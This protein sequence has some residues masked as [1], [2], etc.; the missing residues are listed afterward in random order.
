MALRRASARVVQR[1]LP[2]ATLETRVGARLDERLHAGRVVIRSGPVQRGHL[3]L[4]L[5]I[6]VGAA[7]DEMVKAAQLAE[8]CRPHQRSLAEPVG[9]VEVGLELYEAAEGVEV[10]LA[11]SVDQSEAVRLIRRL[12]LHRCAARYRLALATSSCLPLGRGAAT[13]LCHLLPAGR[14]GATSSC[15]LPF[16]PATSSVGRAHGLAN[17]TFGRKATGRESV[18]LLYRR[19]RRVP[20]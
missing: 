9:E 16:A 7:V 13:S 18:H 20:R 19:P 8:D 12:R 15:H 14:G 5:G 2:R 11:R 4:G 1:R 10:T 6:H 17:A 3:R